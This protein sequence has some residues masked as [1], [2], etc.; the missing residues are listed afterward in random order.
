LRSSRLAAAVGTGLVFIL[1]GAGCGGSSK[2]SPVASN[3]E[4]PAAT[5]AGEAAVI[6]A[7]NVQI[8][9][10]T[11]LHWQRAIRLG[12]VSLPGSSDRTKAISYLITGN[13]VIEEA[14]KQGLTAPPGTVKH[15]MDE[16]LGV[17]VQSQQEAEEELAAKG[18]DIRDLE[19]EA[20]VA[21][22][23]ARL[24][25][26]VWNDV[27]APSR[28]EIAT[29]YEHHRDLF[30]HETRVVDLVEQ[31]KTRARAIAVGRELGTGQ[32][33]AAHA[34]HEIVTEATLRELEH[35]MNGGLVRAIFAAQAHKLGGPVLYDRKWVI[36]VV[37]HIDR[38]S[39]SLTEASEEISA[40][41]RS[42]RQLRALEAYASRYR[43]ELRAKTTCRA[44][45]VAPGC[46][47]TR[48]AL[49][50]TINSILE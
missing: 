23:I 3:A 24:R 22:S 7:G 17:K 30:F 48:M 2:K 9:S 8:S 43:G 13:W 45:F 18:Q 29:Y 49:D 40:R 31:Q 36:F 21:L 37:R 47:E 28:T 15:W 20:K 35:N 32:R 41:L 39:L 14:A 26:R 6:S 27:P 44:G 12:A 19:F 1:A 5:N 11:V 25:E 33:F 34:I 42:A 16:R 4:S 46:S 38:G 50:P 10:S